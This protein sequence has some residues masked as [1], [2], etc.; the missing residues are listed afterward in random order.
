MFNFGATQESHLVFV[1]FQ[2]ISC[3]REIKQSIFPGG[4]F[5]LSVEIF[6]FYFL[7]DI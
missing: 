4:Y 2:S 6:I 7:F 1:P 5:F 3:S